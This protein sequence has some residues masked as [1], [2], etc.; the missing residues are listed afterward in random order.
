MNNILIV[1]F[2]EPACKDTNL[3]F[4][5]LTFKLVPLTFYINMILYYMVMDNVIAALA[6]LTKI[7]NR[8][9]YLDWWNAQT[10]YDFLDKWCLIINMTT[11]GLFPNL[12]LRTRHTLHVAVLQILMMVIFGQ[13]FSLLG[14][15]GFFF[16][17]AVVYFL[18]G[19]KTIQNN[20]VVH[21]LCMSFTPVMIALEVKYKIFS[22]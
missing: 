17:E 21:I 6:E 13:S 12:S 18:G 9:L 1:K 7:R 5:A 15:V 3:S 19:V 10:L 16:V 20:M 4:I 14:F 11:E 2:I 8:V 22:G